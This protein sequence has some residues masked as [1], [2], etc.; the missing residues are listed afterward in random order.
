MSNKTVTAGISAR[1]VHVTREHLDILYGAGYELTNKKDL[2]QPGQFA[3]N[4]TIDV[5]TEKSAF[6]N[7]R[8]LGPIRSK[9]QVEVSMSDAMKLGLKNIPVRD[10]G[11]LAGTPGAKLVGPKGEVE[12]T[13]GVIV[14]G[15]HI[16]MNPAEAAE[17]GVKDKDLV[18]VRCGGNRGLIFENVLIRV[19]KD[20]ALEMH[21]DTDEGNAAL[22][23]NGDQLEVIVD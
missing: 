2:A 3:S 12:L 7:V 17:F 21:V 9:S 20:Y 10:S 15:R 1:H 11:D 4:E 19:N 22:C 14:A 23:K 6:K 18:K 13:E 8:I 16:H 5:V